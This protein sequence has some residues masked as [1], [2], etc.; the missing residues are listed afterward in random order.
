MIG[1][2]TRLRTRA[3][4]VGIVVMR[5]PLAHRHTTAT[6]SRRFPMQPDPAVAAEYHAA[7]WWGDTTVGDAVAGWAQ[8]RSDGDA[9]VADGRRAT[10]AQY[11]ERATSLAAVLV[12]TGLPRGARVAVLLPDG[13]AVHVAF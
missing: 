11:D 4:S 9:L 5:T 2:S 10:W 1:W 7:G 13:I 8:D 12:G 3:A 6:R